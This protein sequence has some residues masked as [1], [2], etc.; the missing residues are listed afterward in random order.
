MARGTNN[1]SAT[2]GKLQGTRLLTPG[3]KN[4]ANWQTHFFLNRKLNPH[5]QLRNKNEFANRGKLTWQTGK[6]I[7]AAMAL[8]TPRF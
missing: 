3:S 2:L 4:V 7:L 6:V 8:E 5:K 1:T